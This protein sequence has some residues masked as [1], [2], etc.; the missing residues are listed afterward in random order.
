MSLQLIPSL[1]SFAPP[2][3]VVASLAEA[4]GVEVGTLEDE[5]I[6]IRIT[7]PQEVSKSSATPATGPQLLLPQAI[8]SSLV[9]IGPRLRTSQ[10]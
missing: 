5:V 3:V 4:I 6:T 2:L 7:V 9:V 10:L 1:L 8:Q